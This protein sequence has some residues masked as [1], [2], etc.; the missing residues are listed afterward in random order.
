M[1]VDYLRNMRLNF[2]PRKQLPVGASV[3]GDNI[4]PITFI[5]NL[6]GRGGR[7]KY[8]FKSLRE[9]LDLCQAISWRRTNLN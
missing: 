9:M 5:G 4:G 7:C 2:L 3:I 6:L 1:H 8:S